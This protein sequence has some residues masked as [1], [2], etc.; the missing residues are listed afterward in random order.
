MKVKLLIIALVIAG[1]VLGYQYFGIGDLLS[2]DS[3]KENREM[4]LQ[5]V[6][7][8]PVWFIGVFSVAYFI[9]VALSL[10]VASVLSL[11]AGFLFGSLMGTVIVVVVA[12]LGAVVVFELTRKLFGEQLQKRYG[13]KLQKLTDEIE[14]NGFNHLLFLRLIPLFPFFLVN[15]APAL[16]TMRL[17]TYAL[18]TFLGII[19]GSFIYVN[20][21][22]SLTMIDS[23]GD[24]LTPQVLISLIL[25]GVVSLIPVLVK[26]WRASS[27][28]NID[29]GTQVR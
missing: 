14:R 15:I 24:V 21:G 20:A 2:L 1:V 16:S 9:A 22:Q 13:S 25:L 28:T 6:D 26:K 18:A 19:P 4:L 12:T 5:E 8:R 23:A 17:R 10:P 27:T 3:I 7:E 11:L 29:S